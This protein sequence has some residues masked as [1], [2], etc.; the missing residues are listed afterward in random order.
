MPSLDEL[1]IDPTDIV[2]KL[3]AFRTFSRQVIYMTLLDNEELEISVFEEESSIEEVVADEDEAARLKLLSAFG[4]YIFEQIA[5]D[6]PPP[7][8]LSI[9]EWVILA[10][11]VLA[12]PNLRTYLPVLARKLYSL[13]RQELRVERERAGII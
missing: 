11:E 7:D 6:L 2:A 9:D 13:L 1:D 3:D 4:E 10:E 12:P 5:D 8:E